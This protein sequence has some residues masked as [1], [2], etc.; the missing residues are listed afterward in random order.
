MLLNI[1]Q[2]TCTTI[3]EAS[4]CGANCANCYN[5]ANSNAN[6]CVLCNT[7]Y[8]MIQGLC[9]QCPLGCDGCIID[10]DTAAPTCPSCIAGFYINSNT[11]TC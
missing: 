4:T 2:G 9:V 11:S 7:G 1:A 5:F 8:V 6:T 3:N 10:S